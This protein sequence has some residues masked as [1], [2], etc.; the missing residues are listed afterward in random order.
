M[1]L[2]VLLGVAAVLVASSPLH[3]AK[4][5]HCN[6]GIFLF[7][8]NSTPVD[9][10]TDPARKIGT[11]TLT[12]NAIGCLVL[13]E[14]PRTPGHEFDTNYIYPGADTLVVRWL[15]GNADAVGTLTFAGETHELHFRAT[16]NYLVAVTDS[17]PIYIDP[18]LSITGGEAVVHVCPTPDALPEDCV[19]TSY[20]T[21]G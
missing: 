9:D 3:A 12:S 15:G 21:L 8:Y 5:D 6:T 11:V 7:S 18:A 14:D 20:R 17:Q 16:S 13:G 10:P 1:R 4:A 19:T 2:R